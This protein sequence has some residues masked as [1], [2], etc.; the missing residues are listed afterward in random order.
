MVHPANL[1]KHPKRLARSLRVPEPVAAQVLKAVQELCVERGGVRPSYNLVEHALMA[2]LA[3]ASGSSVK[4]RSHNTSPGSTS[5]S[6]MIV[7]KTY[8]HSGKPVRTGEKSGKI[9]DRSSPLVLESKSGRRIYEYGRYCSD[10]G[11]PQKSLTKYSKSN[12]GE[13]ALCERCKAKAFDRSHGPVDAARVFVDARLLHH[14]HRDG[15]REGIR[16]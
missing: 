15:K 1:V 7:R 16:K 5:E 13:V 8:A 14:D 10:C 6:R 4:E 12:W 9:V 2:A 11:R 3:G